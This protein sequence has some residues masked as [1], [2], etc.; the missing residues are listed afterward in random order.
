MKVY[1]T[2]NGRSYI[3]LKNGMARF[4]KSSIKKSNKKIKIKTKVKMV[5]K[6]RKY[7]RNSNTGILG[8]LNKPFMGAAGVV[9]YESFISP[10]IPIQGVAKDL[11]ELV[12]GAYLSKKSGFLGATGRSLVVI[13]SY[14]LLSG[15]VGNKLQGLIGGINSDSTQAY[16][17][18]FN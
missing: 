3:K 14:Q 16:A 7:K 9:L 17:Y 1:K 8:N 5:K 11:L 6:I 2:K 10:V 12:G 4:I 18:N 15:M 13:N